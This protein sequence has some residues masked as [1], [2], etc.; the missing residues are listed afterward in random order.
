MRIAIFG[1]GAMGCLFGARLSPL[2]DVTLIG[3][4][5]EQI[6]ALRRARL[7]FIYPDDEV[8]YV[9][10]NAVETADTVDPVDVVIFITKAAYLHEAA[11]QAAQILAP[12]GLA[13][14]LQN[15]IGVR[16]IAAEFIDESRIVQG[17]TTQ[18]AATDG[19]G[20]LRYA[21]GGLTTI[22]TTPALDAQVRDLADLFNRAGIETELIGNIDSLVWGKLVLNAAAN[23]L[24]AVLRV[25]NGLLLESEST[26]QLMADIALEVAAVA[27]A[28]GIAL[29]Y[30]DPVAYVEKACEQ[31]ATNRTS[32]LQDVER[33]APTEIELI[34]GA[35][36]REGA[37]LGVPTPVNAT[38]YHLVKA[39][40]DLRHR[41]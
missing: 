14:V 11:Q 12:G 19:P 40:E 13:V 31:T 20:V 1:V 39:I 17:V 32:M 29:P 27:K 25:R 24:T 16:E 22:A 26:L 30:D 41:E 3:T 28:K 33:G 6:E 38:L 23:S 18:G 4:W 7:R 9:D 36:M 15:G 10:L 35:V 37:A 34:C 8:D 21:G 5:P 2:A